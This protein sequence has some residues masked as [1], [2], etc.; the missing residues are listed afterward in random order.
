VRGDVRAKGIELEDAD[1]SARI[2]EGNCLLEIAGG[3]RAVECS[4]HGSRETETVEL[5]CVVGRKR[6]S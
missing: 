6:T 4:S 3:S 2:D 1:V 5:D